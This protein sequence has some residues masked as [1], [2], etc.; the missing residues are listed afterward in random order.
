MI[1]NGKYLGFGYI[2]LTYFGGSMDEFRDAIKKYE[3]SRDIQ[4]IINGYLLKKK[5]EKVITF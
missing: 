5:V 1:E 4:K 2:D 3:D